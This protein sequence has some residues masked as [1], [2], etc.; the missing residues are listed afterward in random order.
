MPAR[1]GPPAYNRNEGVLAITT[2]YVRGMPS[3]RWL[4]DHP[5]M[6]DILREAEPDEAALLAAGSNYV[7]LLKMRH[8][9][10]GEGYAVYKPQRVEAPLHD[11][12]DGTLFKREYASYVVSEALGWSLVPPTIVREDGLE[13]GLGALQL[14]IEHD[15]AQHYFSLKDAH[16]AEMKRIAVFDWL[17]N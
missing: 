8:P 11:F 9:D 2:R 6:L 5:G 15:P 13:G 17:T 4:P 7:Y 16:E 14:F 10:A 1:V 12:P 3:Q